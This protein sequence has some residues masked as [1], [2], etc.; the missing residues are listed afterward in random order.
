MGINNRVFLLNQLI[1]IGVSLGI[2]IAISIILPF[3]VSFIVIIGV[4]LLL[5]VYMKKLMMKRMSTGKG[6]AGIFGS[7]IGSNKLRYYCMNCGEQHSQ[8]A[9][10]RCGSKMKRVGS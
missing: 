6:A 1:W 4:F 5:S 3:P 7:G 2:S 8:I 10:P 9:C